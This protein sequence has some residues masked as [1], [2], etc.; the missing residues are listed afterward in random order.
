MH[1]FEHNDDKQYVWTSQA[2]SSFTIAE[3]PRGDT[4]GRGTRI[5]L[6][7]KKDSAE[8]LEEDTLKGLIKK[9]SE[10][11][12]FPINLKVTKEV[13]VEVP[14]ITYAVKETGCINSFGLAVPC[15]QE[16]EA[17]RKRAADEEEAAAGER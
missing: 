14:T 1:W 3:D 16:G 11:I 7:L 8:F 10:F 5:T 13:E 17:R 4:L 6:R 15:L 12:N 9:Y 2:D